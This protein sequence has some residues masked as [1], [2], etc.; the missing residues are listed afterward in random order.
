M[1]MD[2]MDFSKAPPSFQEVRWISTILLTT[3]ASGW[4]VCYIATIAKAFRD[5]ACWM[6]IIPLSCNLSWELVFVFLYPPPRLP[7]VTFWLSLN[8]WVVFVAVKFASGSNKQ[9]AVFSNGALQRGAFFVLATIFWGA[10]HVALISQ[11]GPLTAFY[12]GGLCCQIMTS[13]AALDKLLK[14]GHTAGASY[15][16]WISR[17]IGTSSALL[18]VYFRAYY[19]PEVWA[20]ASNPLMY[21]TTAAFIILDGLYGVAFWNIRRSEKQQ[22]K[23]HATKKN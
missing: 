16:I 20:W 1:D 4:L 22:Q 23:R 13:S 6:P 7:I 14:A 19:W 10:G 21:W 12:Y 9:S 18:G 17:V 15:T 2:D 11:V 3:L 8:L 5:R